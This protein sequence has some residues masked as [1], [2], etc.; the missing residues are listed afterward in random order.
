[1]GNS[2]EFPAPR[3][4]CDFFVKGL[5]CGQRLFHRNVVNNLYTEVPTFGYPQ[6][7]KKLTKVV[8]KYVLKLKP[9]DVLTHPESR[10]SRVYDRFPTIVV[11]LQ[12]GAP[13]R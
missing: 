11:R 9:M 10:F 12:G 8:L 13:V 1:M 4:A 6:I 5:L 7:I 3:V 2:E